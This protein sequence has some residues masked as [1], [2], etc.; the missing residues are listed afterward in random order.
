MKG[1]ELDTWQKENM[2]MKG[3]VYGD[4]KQTPRKLDLKMK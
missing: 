2:R 3:D 1:E 4:K